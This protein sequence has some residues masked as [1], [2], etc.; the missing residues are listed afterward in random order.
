MIRFQTGV[1]NIRWRYFQHDL[2]NKFAIIDASL[3]RCAL[4]TQGTKKIANERAKRK[5]DS[6]PVDQK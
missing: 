3:I 5:K 1:Q 4:A 6:T 2:P